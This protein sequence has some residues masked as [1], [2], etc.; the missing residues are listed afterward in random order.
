MKLVNKVIRGR[1]VTHMKVCLCIAV[2]TAGG[3]M[4]V[5]ELKAISHAIAC[6]E[7]GS[8]YCKCQITNVNYQA[9]KMAITGDFLMA[10]VYLVNNEP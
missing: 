3:T 5:K 10:T 1:Q 8:S 6:R 4:R 7:R 2:L 9:C